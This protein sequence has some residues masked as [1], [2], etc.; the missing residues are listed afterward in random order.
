MGHRRTAHPNR[1]YARFAV[2]LCL[3]A[4]VAAGWLLKHNLP[5][6]TPHSRD[7]VRSDRDGY[8]QDAAATPPAEGMVWIADGEVLYGRSRSAASRSSQHAGDVPQAPFDVIE[9]EPRVA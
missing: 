9:L 3:L 7:C 1:T 6:N 4:A 8:E 5:S 2:P